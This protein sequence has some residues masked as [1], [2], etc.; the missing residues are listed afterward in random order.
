MKGTCCQREIALF[1]AV[2]GVGAVVPATA[3]VAAPTPRGILS[4]FE[5]GER[6]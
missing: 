1:M 2:T 3:N 6:S 5:R 4:G